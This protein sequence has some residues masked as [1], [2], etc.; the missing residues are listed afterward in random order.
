MLKTDRLRDLGTW[1]KR[2]TRE[3]STDEKNPKTAAKDESRATITA[4]ECRRNPPE[5]RVAATSAETGLAYAGRNHRTS[6]ATARPQ[7]ATTFCAS[8]ADAK[9]L[10]PT[11]FD[12]G[13]PCGPE[14]ETFER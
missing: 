12:G 11:G 2:M 7:V 10:H 1:V 14:R 3:W 4:A 5:L 6:V 8:C 13:Q 9:R